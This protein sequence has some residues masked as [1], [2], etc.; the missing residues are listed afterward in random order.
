MTTDTVLETKKTTRIKEPRKFK[1]VVYNDD[2]TPMEFVIIMFRSVFKITPERAISLT[3]EIHN[4]GSAVAG[5]YN[6]EIAEQKA[7]DATELARA[8]SFPLV[9]RVEQ[10]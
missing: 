8:N 1:V 3:M 9:L 2:V 4:N 6:Y 5:V 10:E 7:I